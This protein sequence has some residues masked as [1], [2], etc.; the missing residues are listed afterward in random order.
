[1]RRMMEELKPETND[2]VIVDTNVVINLEHHDCSNI[3]LNAISNIFKHDIRPFITDLSFC[4]LVIGSN[5]LKDYKNHCKELNDTEFLLCGNNEELSK[6]LSET[7]CDLILDDSSFYKYK[8]EVIDLR[9]RAL[10][11]MFYSLVNL[12]IKVSIIVFQKV[13][14]YYWDYAFIIFNEIFANH[15]NEY[16][17]I[18]Y[19]CYKS[20]VDDKKESKK[21]IS[22]LFAELLVT[23]LTTIK[24]DKY[25]EDEVRT[26]LGQTLTS[27]NYSETVKSL[28][29]EK[30][31]K[32]K[33]WLEK[34]FI[35]KTRQIIDKDNECPIITDGL[36][37]VISQIIFHG[38]NYNSHDLIDLYNIYFS[39]KQDVT[40]HYFTNDKTRWSDYCEV[41]KSLRPETK[42]NYNK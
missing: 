25:I 39:A 41:E 37:F 6:F 9:N 29:I 26:K 2:I 28:G 24:P 3:D 34:E 32:D 7:N 1:M 12:Y 40:V 20:F 22:S 5:C 8:E 38:A 10:F 35:V 36:C 16:N 42:I 13:D 19:D 15:N 27:K 33:W 23:L 17:D 18:L 31:A 30:N 21:L 4:E 11:P 14:R